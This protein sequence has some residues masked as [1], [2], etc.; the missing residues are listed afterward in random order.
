MPPSIATAVYALGIVGLFVLDRDRRVRTSK[1][2]WIPVVWLSIA[3]SRGVSQWLA[4]FGIGPAGTLSGSTGG[5]IEGDPVERV[6]YAGFLALAIIVLVRRG[7]AVGRLLRANVPILL[8]FLYCAMSILWSDY[9]GVAFKRW[10]KAL[11]DLL[12]VMIVLTESD[13]LAAFRRLLSRTAFLLIPI[14]VLFIKYYPDLGT[15]YQN[16][17]WT[18]VYFGVATNKNILGA[19]CLLFGLGSEWRFLDAY[20]NREDTHRARHL[21]AHGTILVM[22]LWLFWMANSMTSL[23]CFLMASA[24]MAA[25]RL[26]ALARKRWVV[27]SLV[28]AM[29]AVSAF[30]L[31][32]D[33]GG[34]ILETMGRNPTLTGRTE[35]WKLVLSMTRNPLVGTGFESFWLGPR[36]EKIWSIYWWHPN[37]AHNGYIEVFLNLGWI[38]IA[39]LSVVVVTGYRTALSTL[40]RDPNIGRLTLAYFAV[41]LVYN[42]TEAGFRMM[43]PIWILFLL[44]IMTFPR[45][46]VVVRPPPPDR[47]HADNFAE[48]ESDHNLGVGLRLQDV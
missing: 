2:L 48:C 1:A 40:R 13:R 28:G 5:N 29:V 15:G 44:A 21:I 10:S 27:H 32:F 42:F 47:D 46:P 23:S 24:L 31:F 37:E 33:A 35:V 8:F 6:V 43:D 39:L 3:G 7:P 22:V 20:Q 26:R 16:F 17:R 11:G 41:G 25:G 14:S 18:H 9:P 38:G 30:A 45:R 34:D 12:M 19:I 36:L 4:V